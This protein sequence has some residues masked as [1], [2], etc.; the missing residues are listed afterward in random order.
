MIKPAANAASRLDSW[1]LVFQKAALAADLI[2]AADSVWRFR[3]TLL[4]QKC[5][6]RRDFKLH[7]PNQHLD[8]Y[9]MSSYDLLR[10]YALFDDSLKQTWQQAAPKASFHEEI[11]TCIWRVSLRTSPLR[12]EQTFWQS[13]QIPSWNFLLKTCIG[14][15]W[16][17]KLF[18]TIK[19]SFNKS[20]KL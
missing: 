18:S 6:P 3:A 12:S 2:A 4:V 9:S 13:L 19:T 7:K 16:A 17:A 8:A 20:N 10:S 5:A 15:A 1:I 14:D 11:S